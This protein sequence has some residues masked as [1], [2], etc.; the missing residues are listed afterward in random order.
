MGPMERRCKPHG[1]PPTAK[2]RSAGA[3]NP[4]GSLAGLWDR[5]GICCG[6]PLPARLFLRTAEIKRLFGRGISKRE[7]A[8]RLKIG[9]TSVRRV[10]TQKDRLLNV[11]YFPFVKQP[12]KS[13]RRG[14]RLRNLFEMLGLG[15]G[16][17][18]A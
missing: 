13:I 18:E 3:K 10:F 5:K 12:Q 16:R 8:K 1:R 15:R 9:R 11:L 14:S 4:E 17:I 2:A 6:G 7:I